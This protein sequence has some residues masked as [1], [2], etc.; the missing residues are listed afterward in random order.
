MSRETATPPRVS[1]R[2][3]PRPAHRQRNLP[4]PLACVLSRYTTAESLNVQRTPDH[5]GLPSN[6]VD[7]NTSHYA[8]VHKRVNCL[9]KHGPGQGASVARLLG[10]MAS[11]DRQMYSSGQ[12]DQ[13]SMAHLWR[14]AGGRST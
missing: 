12:C 9:S 11:V 3:L 1:A 8:L 14:P 6:G 10:Q 4:A 2:G 5:F 7:N 13:Q